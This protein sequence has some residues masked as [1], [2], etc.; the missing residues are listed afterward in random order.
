MCFRVS[1]SVLKSPSLTV[2]YVVLLYADRYMCFQ[3]AC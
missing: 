2:E 3:E 1:G